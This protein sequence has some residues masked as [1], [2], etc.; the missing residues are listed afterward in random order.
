MKNGLADI[1]AVRGRWRT[2]GNPLNIRQGHVNA[3]KVPQGVHELI[4]ASHTRAGRTPFYFHLM[5][6]CTDA[7]TS[8]RLHS[9]SVTPTTGGTPPTITSPYQNSQGTNSRQTHQ[10]LAQQ[11]TEPFVRP[12]TLHPRNDTCKVSRDQPPREDL[13]YPRPPH[14]G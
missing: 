2:A 10:G 7:F 5:F 8:S 6:A 3:S 14:R 4:P 13:S 12:P 9:N 11:R 1:R